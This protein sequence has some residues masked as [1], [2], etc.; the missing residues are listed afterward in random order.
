[1]KKYIKIIITENAQDE[2]KEIFYNGLQKNLTD[3]QLIREV[4]YITLP[5][6]KLH[7]VLYIH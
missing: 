3:P 6:R 7:A 1:M 2:I 4:I 5:N